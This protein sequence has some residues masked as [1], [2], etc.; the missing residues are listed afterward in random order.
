MRG[1][2]HCSEWTDISARTVRWEEKLYLHEVVENGQEH[3]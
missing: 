1:K 2:N 3:E